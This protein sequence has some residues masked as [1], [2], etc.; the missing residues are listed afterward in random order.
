M[1]AHPH[2]TVIPSAWPNPEV[3]A[4]GHCFAV[5]RLGG[6]P[7]KRTYRLTSHRTGRQHGGEGDRNRL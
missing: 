4:L 7:S 6:A 1:S 5:T 3:P 2:N